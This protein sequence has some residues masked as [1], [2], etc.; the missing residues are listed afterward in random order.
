LESS[1]GAAP[2]VGLPTAAEAL[3][4]AR[5]ELTAACGQGWTGF[6]DT[7]SRA[8]SEVPGG[9]RYARAAAGYGRGNDLVAPAK[10]A[11]PALARLLTERYAELCVAPDALEVA[12]RL[13][14][15]AG[16]RS[17]ETTGLLVK[18]L[19][20]AAPER[21]EVTSRASCE[22][23]LVEARLE[24]RRAGETVDLLAC[25]HCPLADRATGPVQIAAAMAALRALAATGVEPERTVRLRICP[26][27]A[28]D[29]PCG[30]CLSAEEP[31]AAVALDGGQ[32]LVI[33]R[34]GEVRWDV[35]LDRLPLNPAWLK[36]ARARAGRQAGRREGPAPPL[37]LDAAADGKAGLPAE[38]WMRLVEPGSTGEELAARI[39][40]RVAAVTSERQGARYEVET[41]DEETVLVRATAEPAPAHHIDSTRSCLSD[42]AVLAVALE[43]ADPPG[44]S[45]AKLFGAVE[46]LDGDPG[47]R[48]LGLYYEAPGAGG[49][50]VAPCSLRAEPRAVVLEI[51]L[52]RPPGLEAEEFGVRLTDARARLSTAAGEFLGE[53]RR[54]VGGATGVPL[55]D[56]LVEAVQSAFEHATGVRVRPSSEPH[57][58]LSSSVE[59]AVTVGLPSTGSRGDRPTLEPEAVTLLVDLLW[60]LAVAVE[61]EVAR[62]SRWQ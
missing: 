12:G 59:G 31:S 55:G 16:Q 11:E 44:G 2:F 41:S 62:S 36:L 28:G 58:G 7:A 61:P 45:I 21:V 42:L 9:E 13:E 38:A 23:E 57:P 43:T 39:R 60:R 17:A 53:S 33:A 46:R 19:E 26:S 51:R 48:R 14:T 29:Q 40:E 10:V 5:A 22:G 34:F 3:R 30:G 56:P 18:V 1:S 49:L 8:L 52:Y 47:G 24:G 20:A 54:Q 15:V 25:A 37:V 35:T 4:G 50:L 6:A 27:A 32:P